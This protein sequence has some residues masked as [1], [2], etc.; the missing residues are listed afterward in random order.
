V[1]ATDTGTVTHEIA[2]ALAGAHLVG[3]EAN[4]DLAMLEAGPYPPFLKRR[5]ASDRG[6]LSNESAASALADIRW[7]GLAH[8]LALHISEQNNTPELAHHALARRLDGHGSVLLAT[9]AR[10]EIAGCEI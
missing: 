6:H 7:R 5:I 10:N 3:I 4:H 2:E 8:V 9:V 1:I